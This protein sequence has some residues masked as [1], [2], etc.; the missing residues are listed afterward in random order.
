MADVISILDREIDRL[1]ADLRTTGLVNDT[2]AAEV[3]RFAAA[4]LRNVAGFS[5]Q[6]EAL[7]NC[8]SCRDTGFVELGQRHRYGE[9]YDYATACDCAAGIPLQA[10]YWRPRLKSPEGR[11]KWEQFRSQHPQSAL[12]VADYL[13]DHPEP[14]PRA[15]QE[16][17]P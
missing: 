15:P 10:H 14:S 16:Q 2:N 17:H 5:G 1:M 4:Q 13:Q 8:P 12:K 3:R 9:S 11:G 7:Y 6:D